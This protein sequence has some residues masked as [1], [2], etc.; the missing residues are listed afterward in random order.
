MRLQKNDTTIGRYGE[1][2]ALRY[3]EERGCRILERN[4]RMI[5][6][7]ID[8]IARDQDTL[9]FVEVKT[10]QSEAYGTGEE[11]VSKFKQ[12]QLSRLALLYLQK[13]NWLQSPARFDVIVIAWR[14]GGF[15]EIE[16]FKNAFNAIE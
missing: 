3:L 4:F 2:I 1:D 15:P 10:R 8:I 11:A 9:C 16:W 5:R 12:R 7:E 6:G 14:E 13:K